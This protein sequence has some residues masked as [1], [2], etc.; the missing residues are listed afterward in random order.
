MPCASARRRM[1]HH[2][3]RE[4]TEEKPR[5]TRI[6]RT[7]WPNLLPKESCQGASGHCRRQKTDGRCSVGCPQPTGCSEPIGWGQPTLQ[8]WQCPDGCPSCHVRREDS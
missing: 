5:K 3:E 2:G 4:G 6:T 1:I 8:R 7:V